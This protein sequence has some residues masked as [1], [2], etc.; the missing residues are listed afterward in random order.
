MSKKRG[1]APGAQVLSAYKSAIQHIKIILVTP[2]S[3]G[4]FRLWPWFCGLYKRFP[5]P[6]QYGADLTSKT[7]IVTGANAGLGFET[8]KYLARLHPG[9]LILACRNLQSAEEAK[10][11]IIADT[12]CETV[13][14]WKL[15][16]SSF[17]SVQEFVSQFEREGGG[18]LDLLIQNA[19]INHHGPHKT[20]SDGWEVQLQVNNLGPELLGL[21][22][23]PYMAK[24]GPTPPTPRMVWVASEM[25]YYV[26]VGKEPQG[27]L[28][29]AL[30]KDG[31]FE[32]TVQMTFSMFSKEKA[33]YPMSKLINVMFARSLGSRI[34]A[35]SGLTVVSVNPS[36]CASSLQRDLD[37][38]LLV[39]LGQRWFFRTAEMGSRV[40]AHAALGLEV[41][42]KQGA[43]YN[44]CKEEEVCDWLLTEMGQRIQERIWKE[45]IDVLSRVD[46][47]APGIIDE[48]LS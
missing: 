22:L 4:K 15:D 38:L 26:A 41:Q 37:H 23:L 31:T 6:E 13:E 35:S 27:S 9:K 10:T 33:R 25:H 1:S 42:G 28:L 36:A 19:G 21:L 14:C 40:I 2:A 48:Y 32:D 39:R 20:T 11:L 46:G 30:S 7:V 43:Y 44:D 8:A 18:K 34:P 45:T 47:R 12:K 29:E 5:T 24:A 17:A 16:L 3:M